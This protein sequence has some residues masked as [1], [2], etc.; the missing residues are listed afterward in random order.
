MQENLYKTK[1][2]YRNKIQADLIRNGL[3]KFKDNIN[4]KR[5]KNE[6]KIEKPCEIV[7][8]VERILDFNDQN[9]ERQGLKILTP[10]Q[11]LSRLLIALAQLEAGNNFKKLEMK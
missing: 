5:S 10:Q 1:N 8:I 7:D 11:I 9:Q 3:D 4:K 2:T 6:I